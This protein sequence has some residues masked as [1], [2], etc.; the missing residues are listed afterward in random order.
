MLHIGACRAMKIPFPQLLSFSFS[1]AAM[2]CDALDD[3]L[4]D[5]LLHATAIS[6]VCFSWGALHYSA[7]LICLFFY[8]FRRIASFKSCW[9]N[10][11]LDIWLRHLLHLGRG[12]FHI[13]K[14]GLAEKKNQT[15]LANHSS[16]IDLL[17]LAKDYNFCAIRQ[18]HGS[19]FRSRC[20]RFSEIVKLCASTYLVWS[21]WG[22]WQTQS[23]LSIKERKASRCSRFPRELARMLDIALC[24]E[25]KALWAWRRGLSGCYGA[26]ERIWRCLLE[27]NA[28]LVC[29]VFVWSRGFLVGGL[30]CASFKAAASAAGRNI[31]AIFIAIAEHDSTGLFGK[32]GLD[33]AFEMKKDFAIVMYGY[34]DI[35][36]QR[37][38]VCVCAM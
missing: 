9:R 38:S 22:S 37:E 12:A 23:C 19:A 15:P 3:R 7:L 30:R 21:C 29:E 10:G 35:E 13:L 6:F 25:R 34:I 11:C 36:R 5:S 4:M 26:S 31:G 28:M 17:A 18:K 2:H 33:W 16:W 32:S 24:L 27:F 14:G 1:S 20:R 8:C